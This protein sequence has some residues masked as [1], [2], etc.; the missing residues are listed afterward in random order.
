[1]R[2]TTTHLVVKGLVKP[3]YIH[4]MSPAEMPDQDLLHEI[5]RIGSGF[6]YPDIGWNVIIMP[7]LLPMLDLAYSKQVIPPPLV[8]WVWNDA[9]GMDIIFG[10]K[11]CEFVSHSA[12]NAKSLLSDHMHALLCQSHDIVELRRHAYYLERIQI[13]AT[14]P[15]DNFVP[16]PRKNQCPIKLHT[17]RLHGHSWTSSIHLP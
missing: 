8:A 1:M 16:T 5:K 12:N 4:G 13:R 11:H 2:T 6:L 14:K 7:V 3:A 15:H 17:L 9:T 10:E